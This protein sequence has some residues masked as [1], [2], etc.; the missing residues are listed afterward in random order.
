MS[1]ED[2]KD[3]NDAD[4]LRALYGEPSDPVKRKVLDRLDKHCRAI[5]AASP[6]LVIG[7]ADASGGCDVSPR[8]DAPGF[9]AVLDE[10]SLLIPD[11]RGN[12]RVDSLNNLL[13]NPQ[14]ALLFLLPGM[15][16]TLRVNGWARITADPA[17][18]T[19]MAVNG[20]VPQTGLLG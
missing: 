8:G 18:L 1:K 4:A 2:L 15:N 5:I 14:V 12:K 10:R 17:L 19:P 13:E 7:T 16:E 20:K 11:R 9:V 3:I 6:F